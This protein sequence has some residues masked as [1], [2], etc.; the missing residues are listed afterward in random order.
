MSSVHRPL[1]FSRIAV[2]FAALLALFAFAACGKKGASS[3]GSST[4]AD[5]SAPD[6]EADLAKTL[7]DQPEFYIFKTAADVPAD[8]K[9]EDG[10]D[11][12]EFADPNAKKGGTFTYYQQDFP[13]TLRTIGPEATGGIRQYLLD[14]TTVRILQD[15]PNLAGKVI[16][17]VAR[18]WAVDSS[19][20]TVYYRIDP[21]ARWSDGVPITT[22]D[23]IFL[24][25][26]MRSPHLNEPWY[27]NF[28]T[29]KYKT[30]T[31][32][33]KMTF[34]LTM[35]ANKPDLASA[36]SNFSLYPRHAM[37]DFGPGW[38]ERYQWRFLPTTAPYILKDKDLDKGRSITFTRLD[39]WWA[40]DKR[41]YRG[42]FN[43]DR[44]RLE[45]IRDPDKSA[46]AFARGDLDMFPL[47][48]PKFWY[49]T[50]SNQHPAVTAG[51]I[52]KAT[53][54]NNIPRPDWGLW[55]NR[56]KPELD[57][58]EVRL[59]IQ[60]ATNF[61]LVCKQFFR[62]DAVRMNTR[63]DG[64]PFRV[65]PTLTAR[66][67]DPKLAR[68]HFAKAG[69]T[70]Q[71][72]DGVL[73]NAAGRRLSFTLS[74]FRPDLRDMLPILKQ[75]ALKAGLELNLEVLDQSTGWK[76]FQEKNHEIALIALSRS[77]E[78]YPRYWEMYHGSNAYEDAYFDANG[79]PVERYSEG[80]PN[81]SPKK[82][83]VQTNNMTST[84]IPELDRLI[85]AYDAAST[86]EDI[87]AY[88]AQIEQ[89]IYD[90]AAWVNGWAIPFYRVGYQRYIKWP[91]GFNVAQSRTPEEFFVHW[92]DQDEKKAVTDARNSGKTFP[93]M[94]Q[95]F[96]QYKQ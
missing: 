17:G 2:I 47:S 53:F 29:T 38:L 22:D 42:R 13:R 24:F 23:V 5:T 79:K 26:F 35:F 60:Y 91:K 88:A 31:V 83:R 4:A 12:P 28:Y 87:K 51:Y 71:G 96:D 11:L 50:I 82:I 72:Q 95:V 43:P 1:N 45:I 73:Q 25:Y 52:A 10:S 41:F 19:K 32:Y 69:F 81:P 56:A 67:F 37:K 90:D 89:I 63:S 84:F 16:P 20:A 8:L 9:W 49:E 78:A 93:P 54:Y 3:S 36:Y 7:K 48:Q 80:K 61:D 76:K 92:I 34:A 14:F 40:K 62:G 77:V 66:P 6:M 30:L 39:N 58:R 70:T 86:M 57:Q 64:Y 18:E 46:E 33:D 15:H 44:Y 74:S 59:G 75:E 21:D 55:I 85:E 27:N 94:I 68:E 65:H